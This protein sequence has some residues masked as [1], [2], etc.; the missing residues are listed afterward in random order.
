LAAERR[1]IRPIT[2]QAVGSGIFTERIHRVNG[3]ARRQRH[4][5]LAPAFEEGVGGD[6]E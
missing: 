1:E 3:I 4:Q 5:L 6:D 2:D